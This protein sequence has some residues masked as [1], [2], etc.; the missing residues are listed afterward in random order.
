MT[1]I[2]KTALIMAAAATPNGVDA[3]RV[4]GLE[5]QH[6]YVKLRILKLRASKRL[7][8]AKLGHK[9]VR[10]FDTEQG[11]ADY[12]LRNGPDSRKA[13]DENSRA[14]VAAFHRTETITPQGVKK[15]VHENYPPHRYLVDP[16]SV[17]MFRYGSA[18]AA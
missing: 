16:A 10:Y 3:M 1:K 4:P 6:K 13:R 2:D 5:G 12:V 18:G 17:P 15:E 7:H 9:T 8:R 11:A 14:R